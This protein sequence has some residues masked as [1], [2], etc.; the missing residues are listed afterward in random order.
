MLAALKLALAGGVLAAAVPVFSSTA[1]QD[2]Q[3]A[4]AATEDTFLQASTW[5]FA[6]LQYTDGNGNLV[7]I[8]ARLLTKMWLLKT[9][10]G[11]LRLELLYENLDYASID[12]GMFSLLRSRP[13]MTSTDVP[14]VRASIS[15]MAFP[16]MR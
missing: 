7:E 12:I 1:T 10:E 3:P 15:G 16:E 14:I 4:T 6:V 11:Q 8:P 5:N 9:P 2:L 13:G